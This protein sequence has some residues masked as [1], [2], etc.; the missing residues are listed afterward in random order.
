M[1]CPNKNCKEVMDTDFVEKLDQGIIDKW[2]DQYHKNL[3]TEIVTSCK[4]YIP[5]S[6][7][8]CQSYLKVDEDDFWA[9][10]EHRLEPRDTQCECGGMMCPGCGQPGHEPV[11]CVDA[12]R[13]SDKQENVDDILSQRWVAGNTKPCPKCGASTFLDGGCSH[14][15]CHK[16]SE[17]WCWTCGK[18]GWVFGHLCGSVFFQTQSQG[19]KISEQDLTL[20]T[21]YMR[22]YFDFSLR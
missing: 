11:S 16:C 22:R 7:K 10:R 19:I 18:G 21:E 20:L 1:K 13:W 17:Q 3:S 2:R 12:K 9:I 6:V 5:C 15:T 8:D 14:M 4:L